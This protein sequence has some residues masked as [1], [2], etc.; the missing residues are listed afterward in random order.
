MERIGG[1]KTF[2]YPTCDSVSPI[3]SRAPHI[4]PTAL[5]EVLLSTES[6]KD[7]A[8]QSVAQIPLSQNVVVW[9]KWNMNANM[10]WTAFEDLPN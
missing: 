5:L 4:V 7:S 8:L 2:I 10:I 1:G 3:Q 9:T 6:K